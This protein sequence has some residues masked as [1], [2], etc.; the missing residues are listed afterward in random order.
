MNRRMNLF[1]RLGEP[2]KKSGL[3]RKLPVTASFHVL[4]GGGVILLL[5][6]GLAV[7][8]LSYR[9]ITTMAK[10]RLKES[11]KAMAEISAQSAQIAVDARK[12][13][14][15]QRAPA[16]VAGEAAEA[17]NTAASDLDGTWTS[18]LWKVAAVTGPAIELQRMDLGGLAVGP[19]ADAR[20]QVAF[21]GK[22]K[23]LRAI[24]DWVEGMIHSI[25]GYVFVME[26]ESENLV[27]A[28]ST[29]DYPIA[30]KLTARAQ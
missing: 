29:E 24:R 16:G 23:S 21:E 3:P 30:F 19:Q 13:E 25:P 1:G 9:R 18:L 4:V 7:N 22:A 6:L 17:V 12:A 11:E 5:L 20:K 14:S 10:V 26:S 28:T 8:F 2:E 15:E 27:T